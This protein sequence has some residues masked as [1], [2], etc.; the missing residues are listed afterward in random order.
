M[1]KIIKFAVA[2]GSTTLLTYLVYAGL[3]L[4]GVNYQAALVWE[5]FVGIVCGYLMQRFWTFK[6]RANLMTSF[7][8]YLIL[9]FFIF[10]I[11]SWML[12]YLV[13]KKE[14]DSLIS[15]A[16]CLIVLAVFSFFIQKKVVFTSN[17]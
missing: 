11:N 2:G 1:I 5:Y 10:F 13:E 17:N 7:A 15:Q 14:F 8:K 9:Y 3:V 6:V 4:A 16:C 12:K